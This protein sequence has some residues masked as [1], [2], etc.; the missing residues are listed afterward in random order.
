MAVFIDSDM[1]SI[2]THPGEVAGVLHSDVCKEA[3][4]RRGTFF[5]VQE[6]KKVRISQVYESRAAN[7]GQ[8][9]AGHDD[10]PNIF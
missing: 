7:N 10:R 2:Q 4:P 9:V 8:Q 5:R 3:P 1:M 6:Y